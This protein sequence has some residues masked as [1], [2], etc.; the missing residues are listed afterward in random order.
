[1]VIF[2]PCLRLFGKEP[3]DNS[4]KV[5]AR[6]FSLLAS[7]SINGGKYGAGPGKGGPPVVEPGH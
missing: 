2:T 6:S 4:D 7:N 1:M 5:S 3:C